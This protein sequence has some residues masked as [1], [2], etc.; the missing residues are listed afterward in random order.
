MV[1]RSGLIGI[2]YIFIR[3]INIHIYLGNIATTKKNNKELS[4]YRDMISVDFFLG[5]KRS[6]PLS[7]KHPRI[8]LRVQGV[9]PKG[10]TH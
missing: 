7:L 10:K 9:K 3:S 8:E 1:Y 4:M 2:S 5:R 6:L